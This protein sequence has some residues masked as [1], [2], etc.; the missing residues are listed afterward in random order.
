MKKEQTLN[1]RNFIKTSSIGIAG[2]GISGDLNFSS[3]VTENK[4]LTQKIRKFN[5][6]GRTGFKV[7]D[8]GIGTSRIYPVPVI[9][10]LL[11]SG[12]NYIDTAERYGRGASEK[13]IAKAIKGRDRKSLFITTKLHLTETTSSDEI[14]KRFN[15]C[16]ERLETDYIDCLMIHGA[17]S[18]AVLKNENFHLAVKNLKAGRKLKFTGVSNHG[19]RFG[20][21]KDVMEEVLMGAVDD[22]RFDVIL[23]VY[24]FLKKEPGEKILNACKKKNIGVTIMKS[25]PVSRYYDIKERIEKLKQEGK[26]IDTRTKN[27]FE[28][29]K[30]TAER[31]ESFIKKYNLQ[32]SDEIRD[33][34][35][36]FVL[37]NPNVNVLTLAFKNFD[38]IEKLLKLSGTK[39]TRSEIQKLN[40]YAYGSGNLYCRHGCGICESSCPEN[41]PVNTIMR[42]NHY[43]ETNESEK[44]AMEKFAGLSGL[45]QEACL[46]CSGICE[47]SCPFDVPVKGLLILAGHRLTLS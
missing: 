5:I 28:R 16:L 10:A 26:E 27:Y 22:G 18:I 43:F 13:S 47:M 12:V 29:L 19:A 14:E 11:D 40:G 4:N 2:L 37:N 17:S 44:F 39:F 8:I 6:L 45:D 25:N 34:S 9:T 33:A 24:N 41:I 36:K 7:S 31:S 23:V 20:R 46:K 1:R 30:E 15:K 42:Y 38:D 3:E 35:L 21:N 32:N